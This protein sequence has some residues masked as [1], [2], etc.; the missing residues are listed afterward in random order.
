MG[1]ALSVRGY[2]VSDAA[3]MRMLVL[4]LTF[5]EDI[6]HRAIINDHHLAQVRLHLSDIFDINPIAICTVL[7]IIPPGEVLPLLL[8]P[9][10]DRIRILLDR[11]CEDN[12]VIP[13]R[14]FTKEFITMRSLVDVIQDRM[15][16]AD[17]V[18]TGDCHRV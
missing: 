11:C 3:K 10:D 6:A 2:P 13:I 8:Q 4:E 16:R 14:H 17:E 15:L 5:M 9:V 12:Q 7:P 18:P 1:T